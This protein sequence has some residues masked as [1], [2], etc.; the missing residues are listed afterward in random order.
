M[1]AAG[2]RSAGSV[3][4]PDRLTPP[5][6]SRAV[7]FVVVMALPLRRRFPARS[8]I[9]Y[10]AG[11]E[12]AIRARCASIK[13]PVQLNLYADDGY[14]GSECRMRIQ[15]RQRVPSW[16]SHRGKRQAIEPGHCTVV[17]LHAERHT[18]EPRIRAGVASTFTLNACL[19]GIARLSA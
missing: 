6:P 18:V 8:C 15:E 13:R 10:D 19:F 3:K 4:S 2:A 14:R 5:A 16:L 7:P 9:G 12:N 1:I 11:D 17:L